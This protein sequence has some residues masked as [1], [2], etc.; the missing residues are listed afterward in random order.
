M[1][2]KLKDWPKA[3]I[4]LEYATTGGGRPRAKE[5]PRSWVIRTYRTLERRGLVIEAPE[6]ARYFGK[7][8]QLC[9]YATEV[10]HAALAEIPNRE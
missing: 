1:P 2:R 3:I 7:E 9:F 8:L 10:G 6:Q 4:A 5:G